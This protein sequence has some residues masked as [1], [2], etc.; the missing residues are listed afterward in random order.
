M[1]KKVKEWV[2]DEDV[3]AQYCQHFDP[4]DYQITYYFELDEDLTFFLRCYHDA[5]NNGEN[6]SDNL[7]FPL[8]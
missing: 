6:I 2:Q 3:R 4:R 7:L 8:I 5:F 1:S